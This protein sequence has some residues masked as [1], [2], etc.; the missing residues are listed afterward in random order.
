MQRTKASA[1]KRQNSAAESGCSVSAA[2]GQC[3]NGLTGWFFRGDDNQR[4]SAAQAQA[5]SYARRLFGQ[6]L[7]AWAAYRSGR[8]RD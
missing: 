7:T 3:R 8:L 5:A 2:S 6:L 1:L 4:C